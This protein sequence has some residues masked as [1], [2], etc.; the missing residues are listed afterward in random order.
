MCRITACSQPT[1]LKLGDVI[2]PTNRKNSLTFGGDPVMDTDVG[3]LFHFPRHCG[4]RDF[5]R[6]IS[7]AF[8]CR[9]LINVTLC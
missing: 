2:G 9:N 3:S 4:I 1:S 6:F 8:G 5:S 7:R